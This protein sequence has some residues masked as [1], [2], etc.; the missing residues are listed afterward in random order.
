MWI[1]D[2]FMDGHGAGSMI[3]PYAALSDTTDLVHS[4]MKSDGRVMV[5]I[6][7]ACLQ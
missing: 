4:E 5:Y 1:N 3:Y 2:R 6:E 7:N